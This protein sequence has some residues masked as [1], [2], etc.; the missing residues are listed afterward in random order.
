MTKAAG[1]APA[2]RSITVSDILLLNWILP[3]PFPFCCGDVFIVPYALGAAFAYAG[4]LPVID[5][6]PPA[7]GSVLDRTLQ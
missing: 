3:P 4:Q 5:I 2:A 1:W 7:A 6:V